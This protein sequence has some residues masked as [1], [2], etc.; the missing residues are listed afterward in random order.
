MVASVSIPSN[1]RPPCGVLRSV[2]CVIAA[3]ILLI[4]AGPS[5]TSASASCGHYLYRNGKPVTDHRMIHSSHAA[6]IVAD[7]NSLTETNRP[8]NPP[9]RPCTG[10]NCS[11]SKVP[12]GPTPLVPIRLLPGADSAVLLESHAGQDNQRKV[13]AIPE[14][15][16]GARFWPSLIFRPPAA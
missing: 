2:R 14:S 10:P 15:E 7:S 12:L 3:V 16:R 13:T 5:S 9:M 11:G 6:D 8:H 4:I 1:S